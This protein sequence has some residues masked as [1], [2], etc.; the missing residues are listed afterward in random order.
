[1]QWA[2]ALAGLLM[3]VAACQFLL[4]QGALL[5]EG[6]A[7]SPRPISG[8][9]S[10]RLSVRA[11]LSSCGD[12]RGLRRSDHHVGRPLAVRRN[13]YSVSRR[14]GDHV[15]LLR[16][17]SVGYLGLGI[18]GVLSAGWM[19]GTMANA[20]RSVTLSTGIFAFGF[21]LVDVPARQWLLIVLNTRADCFSSTGLWWCCPQCAW[22]WWTTMN[23]VGAAV[24]RR[25][26][27]RGTPGSPSSAWQ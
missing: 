27:L 13:L 21:K 5:C 8:P 26:S 10:D 2:A 24:A 4:R 18:M 15:V 7:A 12:R 23:Q 20:R 1:V 14:P 19:R 17:G 22:T 25:R 11:R 6:R 16:L 9:R 3:I